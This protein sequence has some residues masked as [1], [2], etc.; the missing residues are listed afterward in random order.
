MQNARSARNDKVRVIVEGDLA[1]EEPFIHAYYLLEDPD[2]R[3]PRVPPREDP[4]VQ[5][6][7]FACVRC[8]RL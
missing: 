6:A 8:R 7:H 1:Q 5:A 2:E 4:V 3:V